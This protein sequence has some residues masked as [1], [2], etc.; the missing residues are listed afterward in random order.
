MI[1]SGLATTSASSLGTLGWIPSSP[2]DL[3][4]SKWCSRLLTISPWIMEA[5]QRPHHNQPA[6]STAENTEVNLQLSDH[7]CPN[8]CTS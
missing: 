4:V 8:A 3:C 6:W 2:K 7:S 1:E 5:V